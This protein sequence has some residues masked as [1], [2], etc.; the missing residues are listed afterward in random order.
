ME[1]T[2]RD[3]IYANKMCDKAK[4]LYK[5]G[6]CKESVVVENIEGYKDL[7][8]ETFT[9]GLMLLE[10]EDKL[11]VAK[12]ETEEESV[13]SYTLV[14]LEIVSEEELVEL[15]NILKNNSKA[16]LFNILKYT[17]LVLLILS[18]ISIFIIFLVLSIAG[19][20]FSETLPGM[21]QYIL[22]YAILVAF[23]AL[24]FKK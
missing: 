15:T 1:I 22:P 21:L 2:V 17:T 13:Y 24:L 5:N 9:K 14:E 20:A 19:A 6:F 4:V 7:T 10:K 8:V 16:S 23:T 3:Y 11:F 12:S 18:T